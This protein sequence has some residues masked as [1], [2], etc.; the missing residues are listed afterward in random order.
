MRFGIQVGGGV[1]HLIADA[2]AHLGRQDVVDPF[3]RVFRVRAS[4][5][6]VIK[7]TDSGAPLLGIT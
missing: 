5:G 4:L 3:Q 1:E 7:S 2:G 6:M